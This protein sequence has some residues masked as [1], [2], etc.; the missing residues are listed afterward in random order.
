[1]LF[2]ISLERKK[3]KEKKKTNKVEAKYKKITMGKM[4]DRTDVRMKEIM[5]KRKKKKKSCLGN[6]ILTHQNYQ[7][8]L[9]P[10]IP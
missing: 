10:L 3:E 1:M 9:E 2:E 7:H 6:T 8:F 4:N 5:N